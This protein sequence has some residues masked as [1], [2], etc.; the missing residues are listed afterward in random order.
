[1]SGG[2]PA[3][4]CEVSGGES[5]ER[6]EVSESSEGVAGVDYWGKFWERKISTFVVRVDLNKD[7]IISIDE[8]EWMADRYLALGQTSQ[9]ESA[10]LRATLRKIWATYFEEPSK[11]QP[12]TAKVYCEALRKFGKQKL[13]DVVNNFFPYFFNVVDTDNDGK[14][15]VEEYRQFLDIFG[16]DPTHADES[17]EKLDTNRDGILT[18]DEFLA[19]SLEFCTGDDEAS[20]YQYFLGRLVD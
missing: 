20:P 11:D 13:V 16:M 19:A 1:M 7:G 12:V 17:F 3:E 2:E 6:C 14:I 18:R 15:S 10:K 9:E 4:C 5:K 8:F